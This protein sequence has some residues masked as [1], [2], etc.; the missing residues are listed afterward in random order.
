MALW[1]IPTLISLLLYGIAR[2][3]KKYIAEVPPARFCLYFV[4][5]RPR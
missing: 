4:V 5:A 1:L 3:V 2:A